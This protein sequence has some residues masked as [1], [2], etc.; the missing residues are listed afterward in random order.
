MLQRL[1]FSQK[2]ET[3]PEFTEVITERVDG[4]N[5]SSNFQESGNALA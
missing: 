3:S 1:H 4:L 5:A 2:K